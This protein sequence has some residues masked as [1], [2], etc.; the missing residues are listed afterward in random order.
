MALMRFDIR[1]NGDWGPSA[2]EVLELATGERVPV[3][4]TPDGLT[5]YYDLRWSPDGTSIVASRET[6]TEDGQGTIV[7]SSIVVLDVSGSEA[8]DPVEITPAD[9]PATQP[10]WGPGD[11]VAFVTANRAGQWHLG[12]SLMLVQTDG[13]SLRALASDGWRSAHE[14]TWTPD[15]RIMFTAADPS[16]PH[17]AFVEADGS[18]LMVS[19]WSLRN[20]TGE[21]RRT[22]ARP[23]PIP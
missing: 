20:S 17:V 15:G 23:R 19:D 6:Y 10:A 13:T 14:P 3:A 4:T 9:L 11:T 2:I 1:D 8:P 22:Y 16:E 5:A 12:A 21:V 18:G 7:G